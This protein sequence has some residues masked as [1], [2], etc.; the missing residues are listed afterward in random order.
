MFVKISVLAAV[1][2]FLSGPAL[3]INF[4]GSPLASYEPQEYG[5]LDVS[6]QQVISWL[7]GNVDGVPQATN[8][9]YVLKLAWENASGPKIEI[10]HIWNRSTFDLTDVNYIL[11]DVYIATASALPSPETNSVSIWSFWDSN[12]HWSSCESVPPAINQWFTVG[13]N[14]SN[15]NYNDLNNI[16]ALTFTNMPGTDGT[17]YIDNLRLL[18][19]PDGNWP[20]IR[21]KVNFSGLHHWLRPQLFYR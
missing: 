9:N 7:P 19:V 21:R 15:Y 16:D 13:F 12:P 6:S 14:V 17:I 11:V 20:H 18:R 5:D 8:G 10:K 3:A 1:F 4:S 2:F